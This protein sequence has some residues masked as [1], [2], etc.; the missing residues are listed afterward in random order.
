MSHVERMMLLFKVWE[1]RN[2][3]RPEP[4]NMLA[5]AL[6]RACTP[7]Y[8]ATLADRH[9]IEPRHGGAIAACG[10]SDDHSSLDIATTWT[11][12]PGDSPAAFLESVAGGM[13]TVAGEHGP[14]PKPPPPARARPL[15]P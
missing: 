6:R 5:D 15:H 1:V 9:D 4:S 14:S 12:A 13:G 2:G 8:L 10:G 7:A 11:V 3:A